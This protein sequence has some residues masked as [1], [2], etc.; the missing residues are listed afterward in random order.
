MY[1][2][3]T[4]AVSFFTCGENGDMAVAPSVISGEVK[5]RATLPSVEPPVVVVKQM[6][7]V[8]PFRPNGTSSHRDY[9]DYFESICKVNN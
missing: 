1:H 8:K 5:S 6:E 4:S 2:C 7:Q 9:R 3:L